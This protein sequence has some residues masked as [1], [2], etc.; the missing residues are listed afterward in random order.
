MGETGGATQRRQTTVDSSDYI[1]FVL[2]CDAR[3]GSTML[4][5]ALNSN[6]HITC[7]GA[8]F[9]TIVDFVDFSVDGY[10]NSSAHDRELRDQDP[11]AFLRGRVYCQHPEKTRAVGFK[12]R[13]G[14]ASHFPGLL[15]HLAED[16]EIRVLHLRRHNLLRSLLSAKIVLMTGVWFQERGPSLASKLTVANALR[17]LRHPARGPAAVRRLLWPSEAPSK[18]RR[19]PVTLSAEECLAHFRTVEAQ[20]AHYDE[21]FKA[22]PKFTVYYEDFLDHQGDT[23]K[24]VQSFLGVE[25]RPLTVTMRRQNPEPLGELIENYDELYEAYKDSPHAWMFE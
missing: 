12:Y 25:P 6:P 8:I 5:Q 9:N 16:A 1:R 7:F 17:I 18:G 22:H 23:F 14:Q 11:V 15:E 24:R 19:S 3:T 2:V 4:I 21:L 13:Y 20:A 10:D